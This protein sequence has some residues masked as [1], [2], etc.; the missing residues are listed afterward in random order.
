MENLSR[1]AKAA[2]SHWN[3]A[4]ITYDELQDYC[5]RSRIIVLNHP[6]EYLGE[7][8]IFENRDCIILD[9]GLQGGKLNW[10]F[11]HETGHFLYHHPYEQQF[12]SYQENLFK[13]KLDFE[14][15]F[16]ATIA[17]IPV[18]ELKTKTFN[19]ILFEYNY[20]EEMIWIRKEI[21]DRYK[22]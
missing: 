16:F 9:P 5:A 4:V 21:F 14:A 10:V 6:T 7:Y 8:T 15:D 20:P 12:H 11:G 13:E 3:K 1:I 17:L 18:K 19:D 22:I 2:F